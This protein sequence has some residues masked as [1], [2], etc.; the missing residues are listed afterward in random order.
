MT[1]WDERIKIAFT[2]SIQTKIQAAETLP[3]NISIAANILVN[4][5]LNDN[6]I[7]CCGDSASATHAQY[8]ASNMINRFEAERPSLPVIALNGNM[9]MLT[10]EVYAKQIKAIGREDDVLLVISTRCN[11]NDIVKAMAE[12]VTRSMKIVALT[13]CDGGKLCGLLISQQSVEIR[14][15]SS[16]SAHIHEIHTLVINCLS[17][18]IDHALFSPQFPSQDT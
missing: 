8:F 4:A 6:K 5:L 3:A 15:P 16:H 18:L 10:E 12:A 2:E 14:V 7:L 11:S 9:G 13:G 1:V 17:D